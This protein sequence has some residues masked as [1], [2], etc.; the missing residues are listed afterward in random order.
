M[1]NAVWLTLAIPKWFFST[2]LAPFAGGPLTLLPSAGSVCLGIG[3]FEAVRHR[4]WRLSLIAFS[5]LLSEVFGALSGLLRGQY[6]IQSHQSPSIL[7]NT[8]LGSQLIINMFFLYWFKN[9]RVS[10]LFLVVF[11]L[12]YAL[13]T[14]FVAEMSLQEAWL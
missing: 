13:F 4:Q 7:I 12:I 8:F 10:A 2:L 1:G 11:C 3:V 5:F 9:A 14:L 6:T